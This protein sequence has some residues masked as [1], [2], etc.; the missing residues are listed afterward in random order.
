M[1]APPSSTSR[2][3]GSPTPGDRPGR[4]EWLAPAALLVGAAVA[5]AGLGAPTVLAT[6]VAVAA[7]GLLLA[8]RGARTIP[9]PALLASALAA[10]V[11]ATLAA[12]A[13]AVYEDWQLGLRLADGAALGELSALLIPYERAIAALRALA[14]FAAGALLLGAAVTRFSG[15]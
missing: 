4:G 1:S 13:V 2:S 5:F 14:T 15:K 7:A 10:T 11:V 6:G 12:A 9:A 3:A 8:L